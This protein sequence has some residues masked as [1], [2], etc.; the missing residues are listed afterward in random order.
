MSNIITYIYE[1]SRKYHFALMVA[2]IVAIFIGASYYVYTKMYLQKKK[3]QK[4]ADIANSTD[5]KAVAEIY[6]FHA[7]WCPHCVKAKPEWDQFKRQYDKFEINEYMIR[8][9][10]INCTDDT[11]DTILEKDPSIKSGDNNTGITPTKIKTADLIRK[12]G[13]DSYPSIKMKKD[14]YTVD[15]DAKITKSSLEQFVNTVLK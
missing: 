11:G 10:E 2:F 12:F 8:C 9:Y 7:E 5:R 14:D 3:E 1:R 4:H 13:I 6:F 15:F